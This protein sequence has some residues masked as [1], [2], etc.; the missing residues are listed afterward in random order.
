MR[1]PYAWLFA[2]HVTAQSGMAE[3]KQPHS[4]PLLAQGSDI[5]QLRP[6]LQA[7]WLHDRNKH[8]GSTAVKPYSALRVWWSCPHC[9]DGHQH[10]WEATVANRSNGTGCPFCS[11]GKV[12]KHNS[13]ATVAS[14]LVRYWHPQKN[15]PLSPDTVTAQSHHRV[16]WICSACNYGWQTSIFNKAL[17]NSGCP[18]CAKANAGRSKDGVRQKHPTF[19]VCKHH[20]LSQWDH[21]LN[22]KEGNYPDKT[23]LGSRKLIWWTCD[24]CPKGKKHSWQAKPQ[25]RT[26]RR[27]TGCPCCSG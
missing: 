10:I 19:A 11:G 8:L 16:H 21:S 1:P 13:L 26:G 5:S 3:C 18:Q 17:N 4:R 24:Q 15:L 22:E 6:D 12:C 25:D 2:G 20:L 9:P 14:E 7:Q 27:L 23:T